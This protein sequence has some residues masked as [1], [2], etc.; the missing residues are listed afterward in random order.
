MSSHVTAK[1]IPH[2]IMQTLC[3]ATKSAVKQTNIKNKTKKC[4]KKKFKTTL[5]MTAKPI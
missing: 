5:S 4:K 1:Q 3:V 2:A